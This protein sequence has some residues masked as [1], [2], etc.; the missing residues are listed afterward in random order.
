MTCECLF[1]DQP[2]IARFTAPRLQPRFLICEAHLAAQLKW[3][4]PYRRTPG[5]VLVEP[6]TD[7]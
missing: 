1:C 2:A 5:R 3:S 6:I 7:R 4:E